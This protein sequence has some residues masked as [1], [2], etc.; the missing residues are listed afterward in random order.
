MKRI[1]GIEDQDDKWS[2]VREVITKV[3]PDHTIKRVKDMFEAE[4]CIEDGGWDL[5]ILDISLDIRSSGR[6][7]SAH[8]YLGGLE[9]AGHM[10]YEDRSIPTIIVTGFDSYPTG[11]AVQEQSVILGSEDVQSQA[12]TFLG[13]DYLGTIRYNSPSWEEKLGDLLR[14]FLTR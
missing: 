1:L 3:V 2:R 5:V 11:G 7:K 8:D 12:E 10:Y 14:G 4:K 6:G 9:L 13:D